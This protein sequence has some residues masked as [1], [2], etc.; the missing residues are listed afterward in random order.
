[1][2]VH[3]L[4]LWP[5]IRDGMKNGRPTPLVN[6][7]KTGTYIKYTFNILEVRTYP[8]DLLFLD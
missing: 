1:M 6:I 2:F 3:I 8:V 5:L 4:V 7:R